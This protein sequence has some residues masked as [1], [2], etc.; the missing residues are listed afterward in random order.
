MNA[1]RLEQVCAP[2]LSEGALDKLVELSRERDSFES[3]LVALPDTQRQNVYDQIISWGLSTPKTSPRKFRHLLII[4]ADG[5]NRRFSEV[6]EPWQREDFEAIDPA[7]MRVISTIRQRLDGF[8]RDVVHDSAYLERP[9]GHSKSTDLAIMGCWAIYAAEKKVRGVAAAES[10]E[11]AA[12]MRDA[13]DTLIR[14]NEWIRAEVEVQKYTIVNKRTGSHFKILASNVHT[15][16]GKNPDFIIVDELAHW[17]RRE[18]WNAI[19]AGWG[20]RSK[21]VMVIITNAGYGRGISWQWQAMDEFR[22]DEKCYFKS[23]D[24]IQ[25]SYLSRDKLARLTK[26]LPNNVIRRL[27]HNQWLTD[28]GT[29]IDLADVDRCLEAFDEPMTGWSG[30][31]AE[32][33]ASLDFGLVHDHAALVILGVHAPTRTFRL[34]RCISWKPDEFEGGK[35]SPARVQQETW[36]ELKRFKCA[37]L[38]YDPWQF[39]GAA[40]WI[41]SQYD[42]PTNYQCITKPY[43]HNIENLSI[44]AT[45]LIDVLRNQRL[46]GYPDDELRTDLAKMSIVDRPGKGFKID[47]KKDSE[48]GHCDRGMALSML[49][50]WAEATLSDCLGDEK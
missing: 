17:T 43:E 6:M 19:A 44:M 46:Q 21:S 49:L 45:A 33:L 48:S 37:G 1:T 22:K 36:S 14:L 16:H 41:E 26:G 25:A 2:R 50:P 38:V 28:L 31:Y 9:K 24:G 35:I 23:L 27:Y 3:F 34:A 18:L 12:E 10:Q 29:G 7:W 13:I 4:D 15:S 42:E 32:F 20:K 40:E 30:E 5:Q 39:V 8:P 47:A 11:Q